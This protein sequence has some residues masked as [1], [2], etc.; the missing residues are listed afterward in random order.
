MKH[1]NLAAVSVLALVCT[2]CAGELAMNESM[3]SP[4]QTK[5]DTPNIAQNQPLSIESEVRRAQI[6][7]NAGDLDGA[8]GVLSQLMLV[9]P[10]DGRIVAEYG[11]LLIQR[12][13]TDDALQFLHRAAELSPNDWTVYTAMGVAYD[14]KSDRKAAKLAY[15]EA[16][17]QKPGEASTLNNYAMSRMLAGDL[18]Q[19]E[20]LLAQA[21]AADGSNAKIDS[22]FKMVAEMRAQRG[23]KAAPVVAVAEKPETLK[24]MPVPQNIASAAPEAPKTVMMQRIPD[25]PLA[26]PVNARKN[27]REPVATAAPRQ[28]ASTASTDSPPG[29]MMQPVPVDPLAGPVKSATPKPSA[30]PKAEPRTA[31]AEST[32]PRLRTAA[33][34]Q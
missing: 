25:D 27:V 16:L 17:S 23:I 7:R 29:V 2:G 8:T 11:K 3:F 21:K 30:K 18:T 32:M 22:N 19:A 4:S 9:A 12:G 26:G 6:M 34:T 24:R 31:V 33:D 5:S 28:L 14:Q 1:V 15:E 13:K 20:T 10:D